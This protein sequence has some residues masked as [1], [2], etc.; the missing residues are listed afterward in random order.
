M[1][2][3][4]F[5]AKLLIDHVSTNYI[6]LIKLHINY[7]LKYIQIN[8]IMIHFLVPRNKP[9]NY[10][11]LFTFSVRLRDSMITYCGKSRF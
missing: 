4:Q 6:F 9:L 7:I 11:S 2:R 10:A 8:T 1:K 3:L 5:A